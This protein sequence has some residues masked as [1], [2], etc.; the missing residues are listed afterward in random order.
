MLLLLLTGGRDTHDG[1]PGPVLRQQSLRNEERVASQARLR[2][3]LRYAMEGPAVEDLADDL[4]EIVI[5]QASDSRLLAPHEM[6]DMDK[7]MA[8]LELRLRIE[9][10]AEARRRWIEEDEADVEMLLLQ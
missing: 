9:A 6:I 3:Q 1:D 5:P 7:L 2:E 10:M 4:A 8:N